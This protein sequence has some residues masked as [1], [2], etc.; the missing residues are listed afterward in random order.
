LVK[1]AGEFAVN[2]HTADMVQ[3][4]DSCGMKWP[5]TTERRLGSVLMRRDGVNE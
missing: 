5:H 2:V 1:A 4:V 3:A